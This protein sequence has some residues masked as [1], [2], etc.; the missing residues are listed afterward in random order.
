[1]VRLV[2][3]WMAGAA[4]GHRNHSVDVLVG[5]GILEQHRVGKGARAV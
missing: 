4:C 2:L 3:G 5:V 1:M